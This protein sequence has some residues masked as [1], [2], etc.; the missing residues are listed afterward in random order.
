[1]HFFQCFSSILEKSE[2]RG[3][4]ESHMDLWEKKARR[5]HWTA[6]ER[7]WGWETRRRYG[8]KTSSFGDEDQGA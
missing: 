6:L 2:S 8:S 5:K 3:N 1:M 4:D 7:F